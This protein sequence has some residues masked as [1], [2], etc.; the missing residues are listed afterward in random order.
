MSTLLADHGEQ[1]SFFTP[2]EISNLLQVSVHTVRRWI[3]DGDLPAYRI[4]RL[5][6]VKPGDLDHWLEQ[7]GPSGAIED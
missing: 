6:R 4:G 7:Q 2:Q 1:R 3:R 5:W